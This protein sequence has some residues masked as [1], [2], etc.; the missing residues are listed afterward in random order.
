MTQKTC[1]L[2]RSSENPARRSVQDIIRNPHTTYNNGN[3][4]SDTGMMGDDRNDDILV[5]GIDFGTT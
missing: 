4:G 5:I 2:E 1:T 3:G